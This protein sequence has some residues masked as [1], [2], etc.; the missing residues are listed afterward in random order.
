MQSKFLSHKFTFGIDDPSEHFML[1]NSFLDRMGICLSKLCLNSIETCLKQE[2]Y[3]AELKE[4]L[5]IITLSEAFYDG[6]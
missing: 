3:V 5:T 2:L 4:Y 1:D 6:L